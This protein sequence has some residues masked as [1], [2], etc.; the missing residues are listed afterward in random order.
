MLFQLPIS[1]FAADIPFPSSN[2]SLYTEQF[3]DLYIM[4]PYLN[5]PAITEIQEALK[6][7]GFYQGN[8]NGIYDETTAEA[9][10]QF[11]KNLG[12]AI[13]GV[14]RYHIWLKLADELEQTVNK[15]TIPP[16][17]GKVDII[18]DTFRRKLIILNDYLP[19]A[20]FA[21]A[22]GK[23]KTPSPI[24]NW[25]IINKAVNWGTGFGTRWMGINVPWGIYGI[26]GTNKPWSIGSLA[27]HGCFRMWNRDVEIIY[28]WIKIGTSVTVVGNP[29]GYMA[30]G[31]QKLKLGDHGEAVKYVQQKLKNRGFY[32]GN[33]DCLFGPATQKAVK[34]L[35]KKYNLKITGQIGNQEYQILGLW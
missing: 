13:D 30:G 8:C 10:A 4:Q 11:Q 3:P 17:T 18:I 2:L 15:N 21:I 19:Y 7:I 26:H 23:T 29:F 20:Q 31:M 9:V 34:L 28:P 1:A 16:P 35:Q 25:K 32:E 24:G 27:S 14:V 12:L 33:P 6:I 22:I 5:G